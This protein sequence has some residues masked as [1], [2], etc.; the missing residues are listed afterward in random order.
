MSTPGPSLPPKYLLLGEILRPHGIRGELRMR[1]LTDFPERLSQLETVYLTPDPESEDVTPY[2]VQQVRFHQDYA[3]LTLHNVPT[4]TEA[5]LLRDL[6]VVIDLAH[7]IPLEADEVYL[8]ELIG[9]EVYLEAG[10]RLGVLSDVLETGANDVYVVAS[11]RYGEVLIPITPET[12]IATDTDT[13]RVTVR[14]PEGL[15]P[16]GS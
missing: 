10:E 11:D 2:R 4:R 5:E 13:R 12:L 8:F 14:L 1:V 3:L 16:A 7:A 9:M 6:F 15:L